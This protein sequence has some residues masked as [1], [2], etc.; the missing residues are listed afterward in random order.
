MQKENIAVRKV[1]SLHEEARRVVQNLIGRKLEEKEE[2]T[3]LVRRGERDRLD[4]VMRRMAAK[5]KHIPP[6]ELEALIDDAMA[7]VRRRKR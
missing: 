1:K 3:V 6:G 7:H 4:E 5:A 2:V